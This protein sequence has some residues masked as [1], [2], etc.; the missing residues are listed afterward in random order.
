MNLHY[1]CGLS[2]GKSWLNVDASPT[3]R[4]QRLPVVGFVFRR[5][6]KPVFPREI[7]YGDIV[8]GLNL[9]PESCDVIFCSHV[10]EHLALEDCRRALANTFKYLRPGGTF[11]AVLPS[12]ETHIRDYIEN[13]APEAALKF[14]RFSNLGWEKRG[15]GLKA[16]LR[17]AFGNTR[18]LWMWDFKAMKTELEKVGFRE[19]KPVQFGDSPNPVFAE[20]EIPERFQWNPLAFECMK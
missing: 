12:L 3:L 1:G 11:R 2:P 8:R 7:Q 18:H 13:P 5:V 16:R 19:V 6:L 17:D 9:Q 4:L 15:S 14:M 20:V 10:L